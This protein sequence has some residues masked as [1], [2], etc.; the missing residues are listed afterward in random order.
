MIVQMRAKKF[1]AP[2]FSSRGSIFDTNMRTTFRWPRPGKQNVEFYTCQLLSN[3]DSL[4]FS[5]E[6]GEGERWRR[7][8]TAVHEAL[9][10]TIIKT[11]LRGPGTNNGVGKGMGRMAG[12]GGAIQQS[13]YDSITHKFSPFPPQH[14]CNTVV[15]A[16]TVHCTV[17]SSPPR[18]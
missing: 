9:K 15:V 6:E 16:T 17:V 7:Q 18:L 13:G 1:V 12:R 5:S 4:Y 3:T 8:Q 14:C 2:P 10:G 11:R